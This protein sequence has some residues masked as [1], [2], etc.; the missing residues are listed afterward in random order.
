M[1]KI[2]HIEDADIATLRRINE[3]LFDATILK[4][5]DRRD[6]ANL[7]WLILERIVTGEVDLKETQDG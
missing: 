1:T 2:N 4:D 3:R 5:G 6:L 7:M